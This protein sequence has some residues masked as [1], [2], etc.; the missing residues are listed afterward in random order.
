MIT[1]GCASPESMIMALEEYFSCFH[2]IKIMKITSFSHLRNFH[3][4]KVS[5]RVVHLTM[6]IG[7][8]LVLYS[9]TTF[10]HRCKDGERGLMNI[11]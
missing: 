1:C 2:E 8:L 5:P 4:L 7:Q 3:A 11:A 10:L 6:V 9:Q